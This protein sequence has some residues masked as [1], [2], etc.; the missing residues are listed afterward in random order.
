MTLDAHT[1]AVLAMVGG[2]NYHKSQFNLATQGERQP[3]SSFKP[4]VLATALKSG[5][6]PATTFV[7][8]PVTIDAGGRIWNV[9]NYE[10]AYNGTID[11]R[12]AIAYSDNSVF[13]QLTNVVGPQ[14]VAATAKALGIATPLNGYFAIGLG[15][16]PATP[17]DMARAYAAFANGGWRMDGAIFGNEPRASTC[18]RDDDGNCKKANAYVAAARARGLAG[19]SD[20]RPPAGRRHLRHRQGGADPRLSP[21]PARPARRRT[22]ATR[23]SSATRPTS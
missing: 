23:G 20:R 12:Q 22:T 16:E 19:G 18:L 14:N 8:R 10:S 17:L 4:F 3:G 5:I 13:A 6:S 21:S 7:S 9:S 2:R 11:L 1:G 15:A